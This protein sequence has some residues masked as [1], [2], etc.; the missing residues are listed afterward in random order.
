MAQR[1]NVDIG[2]QI[3]IMSPIDQSNIFGLPQ[4][5]DVTIS[6]IFHAQ[7]LD[8]DDRVVF[9]STPCRQPPIP[10]QAKL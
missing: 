1:L 5:I 9:I 8:F 6:R 10:A 2:D 4:M 3:K 7:V